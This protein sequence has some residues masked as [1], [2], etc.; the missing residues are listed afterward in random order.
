VVVVERER[1][2][3]SHMCIF[4]PSFLR[5][6][7]GFRASAL[8]PFYRGAPDQSVVFDGDLSKLMPMCLTCV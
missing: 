5:H 3:A 6:S 4:A 7:N 8:V 2:H 1:S